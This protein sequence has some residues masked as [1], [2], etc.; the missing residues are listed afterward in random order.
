M[1]TS[2]PGEIFLHGQFLGA[3]AAHR[4]VPGFD[5]SSL[6]PTV[7][8]HEVQAHTHADAHFVLLLE[9]EYLS[10][11]HGAAAVCRGPTLIYNPPGTAHRDRFRGEGGRFVAISVSARALREFHDAAQLSDHA[12]A[13]VG[14]GLQTAMQLAAAVDAG[15][16]VPALTLESWCS[17]LLATTAMF[18][19]GR[20]SAPPSWLLRVRELLHDGCGAELTLGELAVAAGVHPVHLTRAFRRHYRCTPGEYL[21]RCRLNQGAALLSNR[22]RSLSEI[23]SACG[24]FDQAHFSRSFKQAYGLSPR[25]YRAQQTQRSAP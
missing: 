19:D 11:A 2:N 18:D 14:D 8:E 9:G 13:I 23:A 16:G 7:P 22:R 24:Y 12:C 15:D 20:S 3:A 4:S 1:R 10:S 17:E 6:V 5:L 21:R 25:A